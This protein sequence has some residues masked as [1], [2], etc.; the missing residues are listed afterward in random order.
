[1]HQTAAAAET[2]AAEPPRAPSRGQPVALAGQGEAAHEHRRRPGDDAAPSCMLMAISSG[3]ALAGIGIALFFWLRRPLGRRR[4]SRASFSGVHRLLLN[5]YY[6]DEIYD[7]VDRPADQAAVD[8]RPVE[9]VDA[10]LID[11]SVNG[12][13]AG[14]QSSARRCAACRPGRCG[15]TRRRSSSAW[16]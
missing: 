1:M 9:G 14:V 4:R 12:V 11:G 6:V 2:P 15:P 3:I 16:C 8:R 10:G 13:G 5:K 7:A